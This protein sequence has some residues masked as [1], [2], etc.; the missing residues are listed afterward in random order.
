MST[1]IKSNKTVSILLVLVIAFTFLATIQFALA[2]SEKGAEIS[3]SH[4][5]KVATVVQE[6]EKIASKD[7]NIS[8]DVMA[9]A[10]E[11]EQSNER[12]TEA[13]EKVETRG[14][15]KTFLIG[16]D[17]KNIGA[18]R[19]ELVTTKNHIDRLMKAGERTTSDE[20]KSDLGAQIAELEEANTNAETFIQ[21]NEDKFSLFGWVAR[22]FN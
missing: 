3:Q 14:G 13:M 21:E 4:K 15:F 7:Q 8:E 10:K 5:S 19:S 22:L 20:V 9:V 2:Q 11:Q 12:A 16:T 18:L 6:L 1:Y 17:Y